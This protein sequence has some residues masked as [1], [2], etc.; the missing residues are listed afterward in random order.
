LIHAS[1]QLLADKD[2]DAILEGLLDLINNHEGVV[3]R[4]AG[5]A[6]RV[7]EIALEHDALAKQGSETFAQMPYKTPI[8]DEVA[9]VMAR[10][11]REPG[12][13]KNLI[14][15]FGDD[16][17]ITEYAGSKHMGETLSKF[18]SFRDEVTYL[19]QDPDDLNNGINGPPLNVTTGDKSPPKTPVDPTKPRTGKNR[20]CLQRSLQIIHDANNAK[21]CNKQDAIIYGR[22]LG[23]D[24]E[25][26]LFGDTFD[27]CELFSF[28][29][30]GAFYLGAILPDDHPKRSELKIDSDVL[31]GLL[32][33]FGAFGGNPDDIFLE[34][35]EIT[36]MTLHPSPRALNRLVFFGAS[37]DHWGNLP[38][39]DFLNQNTQTNKFVS[40]L[41]E[42]VSP[43]VCP[44]QPNGTR[45]CADEKDLLRIRDANTIFLWEHFGFYDY[46]RP[47]MTVF[48]NVS[49]VPDLSSCDVNDTRGEQIFI[50]IV[51]T[52]SRHWPG[53]EH[54]EECDSTGDAASNARYCSE[55]GVNTYEPILADAFKSDLI[56]ALVEFSKVATEVS[57]ITV[58]RGDSAGQVWT[59]GEVLERV[60]RFLFDTEYAAS[61]G[62]VDRKGSKSTKWV[63]GRPQ[64]QLTGYS[65]FADAL[66]AIDVRFDSACACAG[67]EGQELID[68]EGGYDACVADAERRKG[69]WKRSRSQIVDQFLAIEGEGPGAKFKNA[70]TPKVLATLIE[71]LREQLNANCPSR[72]APANVPCTWAKKELGDK[73]EET[74]SGPVFAALMDVQE[75]LRADEASRR[76]LERLLTYLLSA[77]SED[78]AFQAT[79]GS[80]TDLMQLLA[81]DGELSPI[82]RAVSGAAG[83]GDDPEGAGAGDTMVKVLKALTGDEYDKYH[84]LDHV[85]PALVTPMDG[86]GG[87]GPAPIE[88]FMDT[89]AEVNQIDA[90]GGAPLVADD[91]KAIMGT[92]HDFMSSKTRGL[93][94]FYFIVQNRPRE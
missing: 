7:R 92:V 12:L 85:L 50:D 13:V 11:T 93:E 18:V 43:S 51:D 78:D 81:N 31:S 58:K 2:S 17:I 57:A 47:I 24:V 87:D 6:L 38:D 48:A 36:G 62:M 9:A 52:L 19:P 55:A 25:Y 21:A 70:A 42:P 88:V 10:I 20:S 61:V 5:A 53:K 34:S 83:A 28:D 90:A 65:L 72:E 3:A 86:D 80:I 46:L 32:A 33:A 40:G 45:L 41:I 82:F 39:H 74:L 23:I 49:C 59:G 1:G 4:L 69:Q 16:A 84:I 91:Y 67:K 76:E 64:D 94:Q 29:N 77:A 73:L 60:T 37:S 89:I 71:L 56:P 44:M 68:C 66:R 14:A 26:P 22:F 8:W 27:E 79:L 63:D 75:A 54:G 35:S 30:L 15:A